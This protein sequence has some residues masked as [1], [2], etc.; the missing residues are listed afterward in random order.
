MSWRSA[1]LRQDGIVAQIEM[2]VRQFVTDDI[3]M[4]RRFIARFVNSD[5]DLIHRKRLI[6]CSI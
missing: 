1:N 2:G 5:T 6:E 3:P 4:T